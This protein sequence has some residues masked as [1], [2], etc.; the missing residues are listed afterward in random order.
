M[1]TE[2]EDFVHSSAKTIRWAKKGHCRRHKDESVAKRLNFDRGMMGGILYRSFGVKDGH[3]SPFSALDTKQMVVSREL[4]QVQFLGRCAAASEM[5]PMLS[6]RERTRSKT[7][8]GWNFRLQSFYGQRQAARFCG[9]NKKAGHLRPSRRDWTAICHKWC[10]MTYKVGPGSS[11][12]HIGI[13]RFCLTHRWDVLSPALLSGPPRLLWGRI[14]APCFRWALKRPPVLSCP[15]LSCPV[16]S[17]P[18]PSSLCMWVPPHAPFPAG[19]HQPPF[20][21][22]AKSGN[23]TETAPK[24]RPAGVSSACPFPNPSPGEG[25]G[26]Y[27]LTESVWMTGCGSGF[28]GWGREGK[29]RGG[30]KENEGEK[31]EKE[32][33]RK[34][35]KRWI[36]KDSKEGGREGRKERKEEKERKDG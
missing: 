20:S 12:A 21:S 8:K 32:G 10:R 19:T 14:I 30:K 28:L 25:V 31:D 33:R 11:T 36:E 34:R 22:P 6:A 2:F 5:R 3:K 24:A 23:Q 1:Q 29:G 15:V 9:F 13:S 18:C 16:L 17:C 35:K 4:A 26:G 7:Q 27:L